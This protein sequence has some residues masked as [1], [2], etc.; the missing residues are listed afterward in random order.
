MHELIWVGLLYS[1]KRRGG[2][3]TTKNTKIT[4]KILWEEK[5][6]DKRFT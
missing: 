6:E 2:G 5:K 3:L 4:K 1:R